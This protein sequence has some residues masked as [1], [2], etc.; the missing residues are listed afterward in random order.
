MKRQ[1]ALYKNGKN[2][3]IYKYWRNKVKS[4]VKLARNKYY[5]NLVKKLKEAVISK[6]W[7][8]VKLLGALVSHDSSPVTGI[9]SYFQINTQPVNILQNPTM[10]F[11]LI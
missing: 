4:D 1:K 8:K 5:N 3:E 2:S 11:L 6:W 10:I 7:K 9:T